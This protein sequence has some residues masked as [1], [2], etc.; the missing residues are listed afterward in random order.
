MGMANN[1]FMTEN[2]SVLLNVIVQLQ[3]RIAKLEGSTNDEARSMAQDLAKRTRM[4]LSGDAVVVEPAITKLNSLIS[5]NQN[6][7]KAEQH[8]QA[9]R[10]MNPVDR[11]Y[12]QSSAS[13]TPA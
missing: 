1:R 2:E 6:I 7:P 10:E 4:A 5:A 8:P 13:L 12:L 11:L 3:Y 9:K